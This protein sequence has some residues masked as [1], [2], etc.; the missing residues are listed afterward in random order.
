MTIEAI[1]IPATEEEIANTEVNDEESQ[2]LAAAYELP[3]DDFR[4]MKVADR[5]TLLFALLREQV[6]TIRMLNLRIDEYE[7][8]AKE[9]ATPEGIQEL[10]NKFLGGGMPGGLMGGLFR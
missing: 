4:A 6:A 1:A 5:D 10:M 2:L 3:L 7:A 8:K 9:M